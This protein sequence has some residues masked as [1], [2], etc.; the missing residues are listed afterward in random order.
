MSRSIIIFAFASFVLTACATRFE[1]VQLPLR[2]ADLYPLSQTQG[3]ITVAVD[4]I[5]NP[6][7]AK[8]Y[9]GVDLIER[10]IL[11]INITVSNHGEDRYTVKPADILL[12]RHT[13]V[14]DPLP[15]EQIAALAKDS[16]WISAETG[17]QIDDY[18]N[19]L[20]FT[21]TVLSP[22]DSYQGVLF[23]PAL[24][25]PPEQDTL[26]RA[27]VLF[28]QSDLKL[29]VVTTNLDTHQRVAFGPFSLSHWPSLSRAPTDSQVEPLLTSDHS[30]PMDLKD[31]PPPLEPVDR[32]W[33]SEA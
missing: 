24:R 16:A 27:I 15:I 11:P 28:N 17:E 4:E 12:R 5:S 14:I 23:F 30:P 3:A 1:V 20:A 33:R 22:Q 31:P 2:A 19:Q 18:F 13:E 8:K 29:D 7:R 10:G 32:G 9:F 26:F 21:D 6:E 25:E